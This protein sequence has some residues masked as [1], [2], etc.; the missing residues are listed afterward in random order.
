MNYIQGKRLDKNQRL[1]DAA[2]KIPQKVETY[3]DS[4]FYVPRLGKKSY[5][6]YTPRLGR[7]IA[8]GNILSFFKLV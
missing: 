4:A 8:T 2:E 6:L 3:D 7:S 1:A 5:D